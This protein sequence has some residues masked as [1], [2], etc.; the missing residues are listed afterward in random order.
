MQG[1]RLVDGLAHANTAEVIAKY[2]AKDQWGKVEDYFNQS[3]FAMHLGI[4]I[5]LENPEL[6]RCEIS[7]IQ[8][9]H[10]GGIGQDFVNGAI[11]SAVL[12]LA[13]GLTGL[14]YAKRGN[15]ATSSLHINIARPIDNNRFYVIAKRN[16]VIENKVFSEATVFNADDEP[17][18]YATGIIRVGI[19]PA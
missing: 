6:P 2:I 12:D 14:K 11:I 10:L 13:L 15:F 8:A 1:G 3:E 19:S 4:K 7:N 16:R 18:V 17:C 9:F 5:L